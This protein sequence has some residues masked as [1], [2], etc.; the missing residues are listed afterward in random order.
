MSSDIKA[1]IMQLV[2]DKRYAQEEED[3]FFIQMTLVFFSFS[4]SEKM[5][6]KSKLLRDQPERPLDRAIWWTEWLLRNHPEG[7]EM[8]KSPTKKLGFFAANSL[9]VFLIAILILILTQYISITLLVL[10]GRCLSNSKP[11]RG[12]VD[13]RK[14]D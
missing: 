5:R 8:L 12:N 1:A 7:P 10:L 4:F 11:S 2:D 13:K 6:I 3:I 14:R 9:D